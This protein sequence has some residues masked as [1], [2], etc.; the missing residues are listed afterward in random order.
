MAAG[1]ASYPAPL[2]LPLPLQSTACPECD[3]WLASLYSTP[4]LNP[5]RAGA[6][7]SVSFVVP[8]GYG[9]AAELIVVVDG[10]PSDVNATFVYDAPTI[11]NVAPN[12]ANLTTLG[13]LNVIID[14][15]SFCAST[16]CGRVLVN[17]NP[18]RS[19]TAW[20]DSQ[21]TIVVDDPGSSSAP[22]PVQ[23][24]VGGVASN[25]MSFLKPVPFFSGR[26]QVR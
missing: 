12:R 24:V 13:T 23:V 22:Q 16:A 26:A 4:P 8:P 10:V 9:P 14:G 21:I 2:P 6:T 11:T 15:T 20:S 18:P 7:E 19:T 3:S 1:G 25:I 5:V 17:G